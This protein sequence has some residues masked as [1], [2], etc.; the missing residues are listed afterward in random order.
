MH[1]NDRVAVIKPVR[2]RLSTAPALQVCHRDTAQTDAVIVA[3]MRRVCERQLT[4][5]VFWI[6]DANDLAVGGWSHAQSPTMRR[7]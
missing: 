2:P 1:G 5:Q 4:F 6:M 7:N 3:V